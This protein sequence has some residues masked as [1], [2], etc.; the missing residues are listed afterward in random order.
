MG[1]DRR[2]AVPKEGYDESFDCDEGSSRGKL[3][4][5]VIVRRVR[6]EE[7]GVGASP[8]EHLAVKRHAPPVEATNCSRLTPKSPVCTLTVWMRLGKSRQ[9]CFPLAANRFL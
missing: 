5:I 3:I 4:W 8:C 7:R 6:F 2:K 1:F 9:G